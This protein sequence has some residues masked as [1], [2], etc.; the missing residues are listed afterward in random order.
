MH[1]N[2]RTRWCCTHELRTIDSFQSI[3]YNIYSEYKIKLYNLEHAYTY[4][5][6]ISVLYLNILL[7]FCFTTWPTSSSTSSL[8]VSSHMN[9]HFFYRN[10]SHSFSFVLLFQCYAF[11]AQFYN[12]YNWTSHLRIR[13]NQQMPHVTETSVKYEIISAKGHAFTFF[14]ARYNTT[15]IRERVPRPPT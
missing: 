5:V 8:F 14:G 15:R 13:I 7:S 11:L 9:I 10:L 6:Y 4:Y 12:N 1:D 2:V 3:V